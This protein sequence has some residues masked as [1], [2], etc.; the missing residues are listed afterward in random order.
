MVLWDD[1]G[2]ATDY[3]IDPDPEYPGDGDWGMPEY[4]LTGDGFGGPQAIVRPAGGQSWVL[5]YEFRMP[6]AF[7]GTPRPD[8][9]CVFEQYGGLIFVNVHDPTSVVFTDVQAIRVAANVQAGLLLATDGYSIVGIGAEGLRWQTGD[10]L[11]GDL[12]ITRATRDRIYF[13][14]LE[15]GGEVRGS[16][17]AATGARLS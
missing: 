2:F 8:V 12:H 1:L 9:L 4:R 14:G 16:V 13:R 7:F 10:L 17:D 3:E 11:S 5:A 15:A 6:G